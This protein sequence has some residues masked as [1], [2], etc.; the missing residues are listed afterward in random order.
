MTTFIYRPTDDAKN[1]QTSFCH[2]AL[3][4]VAKTSTSSV[5]QRQSVNKRSRSVRRQIALINA[6][7]RRSPRTHR[8][9]YMHCS[10]K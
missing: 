9:V 2:D 6:I 7:W 5:V 10:C 3:K 1:K 8:D 4:T